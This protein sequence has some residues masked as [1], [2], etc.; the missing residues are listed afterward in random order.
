MS[1]GNERRSGRPRRPRL[2]LDAFLP[3]RLSITTH[4]VSDAVAGAYRRLFDLSIAQWRLVAVLGE[5]GEMNQQGLSLAT[6]MDK[7]TVSRACAQ[8]LRRKLIV[9]RISKQDRRNQLLELSAHGRRVYAQVVP[10]AL[11]IERII[12]ARL[13]ESQRKVLV[14]LLEQI[15]EAARDLAG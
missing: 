5:R 15:A 8:L 12:F 2:H 6:R 1:R 7:L 14:R 3:Y 9:R 13:S 11:R 4:L 10:E